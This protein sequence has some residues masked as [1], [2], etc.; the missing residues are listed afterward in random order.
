MTDRP[1]HQLINGLTDQQTG[2]LID[3]LTNGGTLLTEKLADLRNC[4]NNSES[5]ISYQSKGEHFHSSTLNTR[6][7]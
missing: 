3:C 6:I 5:A 7:L 1:T 4:Q 2:Q